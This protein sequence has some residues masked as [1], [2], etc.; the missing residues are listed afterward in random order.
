MADE[1][2]WDLNWINHRYEILQEGV[3]AEHNG[4]NKVVGELRYNV[5]LDYMA[6]GGT[7]Y[8]EK[9]I[10]QVIHLKI[11]EIVDFI[12]YENLNH[13][14]YVTWIDKAVDVKILKQQAKD[15]WWPNFTYS[16]Y[17]LR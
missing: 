8:K 2:F 10:F 14:V 5:H 15:S 9:T 7:E 12:P 4:Y 1:W 3:L 13:G 16:N 17:V 6:P 11:D